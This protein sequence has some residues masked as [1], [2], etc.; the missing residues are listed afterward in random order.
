MEKEA[1]HRQRIELA[2]VTTTA[3]QLASENEQLRRLLQVADTVSQP[4]VAVEVFY[5]P[6]NLFNRRLV[7]NKS[8]AAGIRPGMPI[9]DEGGVVAQVIR[10]T[11]YTAVAALLT[12]D[13]IT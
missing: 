6:P 3:A 2:Q 9:I 4:V 1:L 7:F 10:V 13:N 8:S 5:E 12:D 11:P